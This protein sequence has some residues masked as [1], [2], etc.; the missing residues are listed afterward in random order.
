MIRK[1][2]GDKQGEAACYGN[3]GSVYESLSE[4]G[5]AETYY[6]NAVMIR[7]EIGDKQGEATCYGDLGIV[8][9]SLGEYGQGETYQKNAV[10]VRKEIGHRRGE[11][12]CCGTWEVC[13]NFS[14]ILE[15]PKHIRRIHL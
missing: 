11:A 13:I 5:K 4:H 14:V 8:F 15:R 6:K 2:I 7:K 12:V 3:L 9:Q 1:E 10:V